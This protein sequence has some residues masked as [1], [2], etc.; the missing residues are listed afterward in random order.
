MPPDTSLLYRTSSSFLV[1][2]Y[3]SVSSLRNEIA[4]GILLTCS[5]VLSTFPLQKTI[6]SLSKPIFL[7]FSLTSSILLGL[8]KIFNKIIILR[9]FPFLY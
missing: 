4:F 8:D 9:W 7:K 1:D 2:S 5:K 6:L 3:Q